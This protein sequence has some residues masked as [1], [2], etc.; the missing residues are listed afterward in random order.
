MTDPRVRHE[1]E[2]CVKHP[3]ACP[4]DRHHHDIHA[5]PPSGRG[6]ERCLDDDVFGRDLL[7][8]LRGQQHADS[9]RRATKVFGHG[10]LIAERHQ[11]VVDQRMR[12]QVHRHALTIHEAPARAGTWRERRRGGR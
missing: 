2:H 3:E 6:T 4:Q 7:Q 5:D 1:L 8:R 12:D 11:S 10:P 9:R